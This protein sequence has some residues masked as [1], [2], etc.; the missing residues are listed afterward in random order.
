MIELM[1]QKYF[2]RV[3]STVSVYI[4]EFRPMFVSALCLPNLIYRKEQIVMNEPMKKS[5]QKKQQFEEVTVE[6][7]HF[8]FGDI[9]CTSGAAG[10]S[11]W[12][13]GQYDDESEG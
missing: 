7:I 8:E 5:E 10:N 13:K 4:C 12:D 11:S 2:Y 3:L 6:V 1:M 9:I